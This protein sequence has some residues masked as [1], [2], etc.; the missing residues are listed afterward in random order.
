MVELVL[1][2]Y[3]AQSCVFIDLIGTFPDTSYLF[4]IFFD[5]ATVFKMCEGR[6]IDSC[7][8][9]FKSFMGALFP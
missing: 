3:S 1:S 7:G 9:F 2:E 6:E 5:L 4:V 8:V